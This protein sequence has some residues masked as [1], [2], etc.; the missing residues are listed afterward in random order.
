MSDTAVMHVR[1]VTVPSHPTQAST[2]Q[3]TIRR[4]IM[5]DQSTHSYPVLGLTCDHCAGAVTSE[6]SQLPGVSQ[7][8][9]EVVAGGTSTVTVVSDAA[10]PESD[11]AA[12]LDEAGDYHLVHN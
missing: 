12:A 9:V 1:A 8:T 10:L 4:S 7:V 6:I 3:H 11:L 2:D 5:S